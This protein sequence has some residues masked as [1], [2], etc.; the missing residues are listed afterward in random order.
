MTI[1]WAVSP[2]MHS[3]HKLHSFVLV[4]SVQHATHRW[5]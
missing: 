1:P 3:L 5:S 2:A 4:L